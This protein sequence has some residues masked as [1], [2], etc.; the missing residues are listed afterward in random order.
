MNNYNVTI[1][2]YVDEINDYYEKLPNKNMIIRCFKS[3]K[4]E[5]DLKSLLTFDCIIETPVQLTLSETKRYTISELIQII[6]KELN[7]NT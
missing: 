7:S 1:C 3:T 4:E 6:E 2:A 5:L